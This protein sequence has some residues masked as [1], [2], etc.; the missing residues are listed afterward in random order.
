[1]AY[2]TGSAVASAFSNQT[3]SPVTVTAPTGVQN[4]DLIVIYCATS[5]ST[6]Q[7]LSATGFTFVQGGAGSGPQQGPNTAGC[8]IWKVASSEPSTYSVNISNVPFNNII[9]TALALT[10]RN[11]V[12]PID[13]AVW[14]LTA[15]SGSPAT[16]QLKG[17]LAS[18]NS[19]ILYC[20][21]A[22]QG[23]TWA[24]PS[25]YTSMLTTNSTNIQS[26][27]AYQN[28]V[29]AGPIG[30]L[31]AVETGVGTDF[32]GMVI[33]IGSGPASLAWVY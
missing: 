2:R 21:N 14:T 7:T 12:S 6:L 28:N 32:E 24:A 5:S 1:M 23:G 11:T 29:A 26:Y 16:V 20:A 4:G 18:G 15:G 13:S 22:N 8:F 19:D 9:F 27:I 31:S 17:G 25:G 30:T 3:T 10:G 33:S